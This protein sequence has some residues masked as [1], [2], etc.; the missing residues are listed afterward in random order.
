MLSDVHARW[1]PHAWDFQAL[2][3]RGGIS[4]AASV[5]QAIL[6]Y[7]V[8]SA[9]TLPYVPSEFFG[10]LLQA[11]YKISLAGSESLSP[12]VRLEEYDTQSAMP[13]GFLANASNSAHVLTIGASYKPVAQVVFKTDFQNFSDDSTQNRFNLGLGYMF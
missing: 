3:A 4:D 12:F 10:W 8:A 5:D 9:S 11:A 1:Q 7:N 2:I 6:T 13:K